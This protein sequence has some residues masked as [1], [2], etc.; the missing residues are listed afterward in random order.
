MR[1]GRP[2]LD[3]ERIHHDEASLALGSGRP[4]TVIV[5]MCWP[6]LKSLIVTAVV[7]ISSVGRAKRFTSLGGPPSTLTVAIPMPG[8]GRRSSGWRS[9]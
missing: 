3:I 5:N 6:G 8:R 2:R 7:W 4:V 9:R 1:H